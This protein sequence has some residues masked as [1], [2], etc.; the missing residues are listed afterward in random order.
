MKRALNVFAW[1]VQTCNAYL[2]NYFRQSTKFVTYTSTLQLKTTVPCCS[3]IS[4][5]SLRFMLWLIFFVG[6]F[7]F[8]TKASFQTSIHCQSGSIDYSCSNTH[9]WSLLCIYYKLVTSCNPS[10]HVLRVS[11]VNENAKKWMLSQLRNVASSGGKKQYIRPIQESKLQ[12]Q[13]EFISDLPFQRKLNCVN[14]P[15]KTKRETKEVTGYE[16][17][18]YNQEVGT[19][20]PYLPSKS[21]PVL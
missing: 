16:D 6:S 3:T 18:A 7:P 8:T 21:E 9:R 19:N 13:W 15:R 1:L 20:F 5:V 2:Q 14:F 12:L 10:R 17:S 11:F 4:D